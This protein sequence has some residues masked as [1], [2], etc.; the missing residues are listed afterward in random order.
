MNSTALSFNSQVSRCEYLCEPGR[1]KYFRRVCVAAMDK[2]T[3]A[4]TTELGIIGQVLS[5]VEATV[6]NPSVVVGSNL[7]SE[8]YSTYIGSGNQQN[9]I[10]IPNSTFGLLKRCM[11][12]SSSSVFGSLD[13]FSTTEFLVTRL[14]GGEDRDWTM[15]FTALQKA[16]ISC[17]LTMPGLVEA[18]ANFVSVWPLIVPYLRETGK[19]HIGDSL[20]VQY[21]VLF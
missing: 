16:V 11:H 14:K 1:K 5:S 10:K 12:K 4:A 21:I 6:P 8:I 7:L 9:L 15:L 20:V 18:M 13:V 17:D 19:K 2:F 3:C